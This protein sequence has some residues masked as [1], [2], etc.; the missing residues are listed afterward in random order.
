MENIITKIELLRK[1]YISS[2]TTEKN[3]KDSMIITSNRFLLFFTMFVPVSVVI[4]LGLTVWDEQ[5]INGLI[6]SI[7]GIISSVLFSVRLLS[8]LT[9]RRIKNDREYIFRLLDYK[10]SDRFMNSDINH[11]IAL[12]LKTELSLDQYKSLHMINMNQQSLTYQ[13]VVAFIENITEFDR[14]TNEIED[15]KHCLSHADIDII[16]EKIIL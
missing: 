7:F 11:E 6:F 12:S 8:V 3:I 9:Y 4:A 2:I 15:N 10:F 13:N 5:S 1:E 16:K 14:F